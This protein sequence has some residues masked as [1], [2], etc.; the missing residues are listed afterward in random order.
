MA[1]ARSRRRT[2][3]HRV[4]LDQAPQA[5]LLG[6]GEHDLLH[7]QAARRAG[8]RLRRVARDD[9]LAVDL[10]AA[11]LEGL[12]GRLNQSALL[13]AVAA[14]G[15]QPRVGQAERRA[16]QLRDGQHRHGLVAGQRGAP[17]DVRLGEGHA[18]GG[19]Q[20]GAPAR[21]DLGPAPAQQRAHRPTRASRRSAATRHRWS[22]T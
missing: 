18:G 22:G 15:H 20:H 9:D 16:V 1:A 13:L 5:A 4:A 19:E 6:G 17:G 14:G 3:A 21:R 7:L 2:P 10:P 11:P 12:H 8:D